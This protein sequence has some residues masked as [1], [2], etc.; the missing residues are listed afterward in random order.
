MAGE[1]MGTPVYM[2]PEQA[3]GEGTLDGRTDIYSLGCVLYEMLAGDPPFEGSTPQAMIVAHISTPP[4]PL[5]SK[6]PGLPPGVAATVH[7]ALEKSPGDRYATAGDFRD[8]LDR[9]RTPVAPRRWWPTAVLVTAVA[10]FF[11]WSPWRKRTGDSGP[12][13]ACAL[14]RRLDHS[15]LT[16]QA[17]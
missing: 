4:P 11:W 9:L 2:S 7:R 1:I 10:A 14:S 15:R 13:T 17:R 5:A 12:G 8:A 6:R 16:R 3:S